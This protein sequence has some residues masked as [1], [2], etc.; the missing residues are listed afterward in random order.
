MSVVFISYENEDRDFADALMRRQ[1]NV[2]IPVWEQHR[3]AHSPDEWYTKIDQ[4]LRNASVLMVIMTPAAK[5]S[6]LVTYEWITKLAL[7][8]DDKR[9]RLSSWAS[10]LQQITPALLRAPLSG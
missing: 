5:A 1:K 3:A 2:D 9:R 8:S 6:E 4:A 10:V 7:Y